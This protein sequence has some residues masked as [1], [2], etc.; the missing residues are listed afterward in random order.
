MTNVC[1]WSL[2]NCLQSNYS[3]CAFFV[4]FGFDVIGYFLVYLGEFGFHIWFW[5][6]QH[7]STSITVSSD[8]P[9]FFFCAPSDLLKIRFAA[10]S[11]FEVCLMMILNFSETHLFVKVVI[12][13]FQFSTS[14]LSSYR[15]IMKPIRQGTHSKTYFPQSV[16]SNSVRA[17]LSFSSR[18]WTY[19]WPSGAIFQILSQTCSGQELDRETL[20]PTQYFLPYAI[21]PPISYHHLGVTNL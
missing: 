1:F 5:N 2:V 6:F 7:V 11:F 19:H 10:F 21:Q 20:T 15:H 16:I 13:N 4:D 3:Y 8:P 14:G 9:W 17:T 12:P 18:W